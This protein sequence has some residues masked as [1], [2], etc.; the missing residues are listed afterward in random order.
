MFFTKLIA[1]QMKEPSGIVGRFIIARG[2]NR[3]N[4]DIFRSAI[5]ILDVKSADRVLDIGFGGGA[6]MEKMIGLAS[7]GLIAGVETS[8]VMLKQ[9]RKKFK[10]DIVQGKVEL[11]EGSASSIPYGNNYFD[12]I[13]TINCIYFWPDPVAGLKETFRVLKP[14]R[15][16][17]VANYLKEEFERYPPSRYGF[18]IYS[19]NQLQKLLEDS[20][21]SEIKIE[22]RASK[23]FTSIFAIGKKLILSN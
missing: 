12:K 9:G 2:M 8:S 11:K 4:A 17:V 23:P 21:F 10:Q 19:D 14:G 7:N 5:Q 22:H 16:L 6:T 15:I 3:T 18:N 20:G 13:C 1:K